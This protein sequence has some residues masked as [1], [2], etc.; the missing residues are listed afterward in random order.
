MGYKIEVL[1][2][3]D[4]KN[5]P[6]RGHTVIVHFTGKLEDGTK[7]DSSRD[8][9]MPF[10]FILGA[11]QVIRAW[12]DGIGEMSKGQKVRMTCTHDFA[13]GVKGY[14]PLIPPEATLVFEIEII[15]FK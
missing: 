10:Q 6:L 9:N 5:F 4:G 11:G 2:L 7:F 13:Y 1:T 3:G 14:P 12:E 15:D 8:R